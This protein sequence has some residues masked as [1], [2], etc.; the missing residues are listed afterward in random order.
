MF[1]LQGIHQDLHLLNL[2]IREMLRML[3]HIWTGLVF[4]A[5]EFVWKCQME[6]A[7]AEGMV[8]VEE[9]MVVAVLH[10]AEGTEE[11]KVVTT[12]AVPD[13]Q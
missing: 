3:V 5:L 2:R 1:G 4:V 8:V 12:E 6:E 10:L 11:V 13:H 9:G 7:V